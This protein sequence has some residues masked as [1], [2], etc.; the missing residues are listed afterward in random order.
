M[1]TIPNSLRS[2]AVI[3]KKVFTDFQV[4]KLVD[5]SLYNLGLSAAEF[6][7]VMLMLLLLWGVSLMQEKGSVRERIAECNIV[8]RWGIYYLAILAI[9]IFGVYGSGY[10]AGSFVYMEF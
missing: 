1:L 7:F 4:W 9:L 5:G 8:F 6:N 2:T 10:D 3:M